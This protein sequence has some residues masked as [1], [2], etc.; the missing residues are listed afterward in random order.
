MPPV[1]PPQRKSKQPLKTKCARPT[2]TAAVAAAL[3]VQPAVELLSVDA[4]CRQLGAVEHTCMVDVGYP[5]SFPEGD[6]GVRS[7][8][9]CVYVC[10]CI[11]ERSACASGWL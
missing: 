1:A 5:D 10:V 7:I 3:L 2:A 11:C 9:V 8:S 6:V 4:R